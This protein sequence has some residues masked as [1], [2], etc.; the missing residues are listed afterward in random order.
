MVFE[1]GMSKAGFRITMSYLKK[2][3]TQTLRK[4]LRPCLRAIALE[5]QSF[6]RFHEVMHVSWIIDVGCDSRPE[7]SSSACKMRLRSSANCVIRDWVWQ[8]AFPAGAWHSMT[9]FQKVV[10]FSTVRPLDLISLFILCIGQFRHDPEKVRGWYH[11]VSRE[12]NERVLKFQ[13]VITW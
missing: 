11:F 9:F 13:K 3:M 12:T 2:N 10:P 1:F 4:K 8:A 6:K 5:L 7:N